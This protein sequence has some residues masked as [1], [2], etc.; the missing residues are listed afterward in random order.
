[1]V[2]PNL[3]GVIAAQGSFTVN[4]AFPVVNLCHAPYPV[5]LVSTAAGRLCVGF[6]ASSHGTPLDVVERLAA[7]FDSTLQSML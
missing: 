4:V 7:A 2:K 5:A 6:V 3:A 1:M